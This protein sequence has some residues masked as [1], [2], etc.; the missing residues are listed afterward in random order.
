MV[1]FSARRKP[2]GEQWSR[3]ETVEARG[4]KWNLDVEMDSG[5]SG[6][7]VTS[8]PDEE[9]P[10]ATARKEI[11]TV[12]PSAPPPDEHVPEIRGHSISGGGDVA[13]K[14]EMVICDPSCT[15]FCE[16]EGDCQG[17]PLHK[18]SWSTCS[19]LAERGRQ[20]DRFWP[21]HHCTETTGTQERH[22]RDDGAVGKTCHF[23]GQVHSLS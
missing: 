17:R 14:T 22:L 6:P 23:R 11:P 8:R 21:D 20:I 18:H 2:L 1:C 4:T 15:D 3:R 16:N 19:R 13:A 5:V 12:I 10:T 9:M 7:L